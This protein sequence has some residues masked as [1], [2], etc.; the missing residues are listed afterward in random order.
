MSLDNVTVE[1]FDTVPSRRSTGGGGR[2]SE[3]LDRI[4]ELQPKQCMRIDVEVGENETFDQAAKRITQKVYR[5]GAVNFPVTT[6]QNAS[7]GQVVIYNTTPVED[8][9][10]G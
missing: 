4:R 10:A 5:K 7:E 2:R 1:S 6:R 3:L 8:N 9:N